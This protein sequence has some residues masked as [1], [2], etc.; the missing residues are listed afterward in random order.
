MRELERA[1]IVVDMEVLG[2][3]TLDGMLRPFL[4]R[5]SKPALRNHENLDGRAARSAVYNRDTKEEDTVVIQPLSAY[6][7][8]TASISASR[9]LSPNAVQ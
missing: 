4:Q 6:L 2:L 5:H 7:L 8:S 9:S 1:Q 3:A